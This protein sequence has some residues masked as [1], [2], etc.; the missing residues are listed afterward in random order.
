MSHDGYLSLADMYLEGAK[1]SQFDSRLQTS[2]S[3]SGTED[4]Y[5]YL[6]GPQAINSTRS[7]TSTVSV[8]ATEESCYLVAIMYYDR[9]ERRA[10]TLC[11]ILY[12][13]K[14]IMPMIFF[15]LVI[16]C[17]LIF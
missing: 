13:K 7:K 1:L 15:V 9:S 10:L 6:Y 2:F 11:R 12:V 4:I 14:S 16:D 17:T 3:W 5:Q 8:K